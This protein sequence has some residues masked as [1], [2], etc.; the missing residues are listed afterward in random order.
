L[1]EC[2]EK[3]IEEYVIQQIQTSKIGDFRL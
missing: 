3:I 2:V 1:V